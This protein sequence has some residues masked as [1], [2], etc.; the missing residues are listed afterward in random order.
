MEDGG[1]EDGGLEGGLE[2]P[3]GHI[4]LD[5]LSPPMKKHDSLAKIF[6]SDVAT[7]YL[8]YN[9]WNGSQATYG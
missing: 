7:Q 3:S 5:S 4:L 1:L 8:A 2:G 9:I 6:T